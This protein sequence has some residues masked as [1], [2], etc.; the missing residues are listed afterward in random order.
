MYVVLEVTHQLTHE[1]A[2]DK[3]AASHFGAKI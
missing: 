1:E 2:P 3:E